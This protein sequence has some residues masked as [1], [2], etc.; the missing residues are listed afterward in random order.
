MAYTVTTV[1]MATL[2]CFLVYNALISVLSAA[3][4]RAGAGVSTIAGN[5]ALAGPSVLIV[6]ELLTFQL[7]Y[8]CRLS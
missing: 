7:S 2:P 1:H 5:P 3:S 8:D 6:T 4:F